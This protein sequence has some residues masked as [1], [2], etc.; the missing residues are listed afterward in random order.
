MLRLK[1]R[2]EKLVRM[3]ATIEIFLVE[4]SAEK[5]SEEIEREIFEELSRGFAK[6]PW[7]KEVKKVTV[8]KQKAIK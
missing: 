3:K 6:I 5:A 7:C 8:M 4:E 2:R 1:L